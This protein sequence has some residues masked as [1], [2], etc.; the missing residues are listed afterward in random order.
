MVSMVR[1]GVISPSELLDEHLRQIEA[2]N[3]S[4]N[5]FVT[6][7]AER[8]REEARAREAQMVRGEPLGLLHGV[9]L[10]VK[11]SFDVAGLPTRSGS[12]FRPTIPASRDASAVSR[13]R[14]EGAIILGKTNTPDLLASYESDNFITGRSNN[15]WDIC[16]TPGGSSGGEAAAIAAFCSPGGIATDGGGSI[17]VPAHFCGIAGLKPTPGRISTTGHFPSMGH[18][19]GLV[20]VAGPMARDATDL[21]LLFSVLAGYDSSDPFSTPVPLRRPELVAETPLRIGMWEQFYDVPVDSE[22]RA[23]VHRA[24]GLLHG[25]CLDVSEFAPQGLERGPN[26]W[27]FLFSQWPAVITRALVEGREAEA[28]WTLLESLPKAGPPSADQVLMNL[29]ARDRMRAALLRQMEEVPVLLMP[30]CGIPAFRHRERHWQIDGREIGIFQAMMPVVLANVLGLPAVTV[31]MGL[32][33][34]GLPIGIQLVGR[35]FEDELLLEIAIRLEESRG[36][37]VGPSAT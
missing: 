19:G 2:R 30:V 25:P 13:L 35:P 21:H 29:G 16:R 33:A 20:G 24:A 12:R 34:A 6:V 27:A 10:T 9:P 1:D 37:F 36:P 11:D 14:A 17:R 3:P 5:A 22:I 4:V 26:L 28:H 8:A 32:T 18:P 7:L 31:P 23:A 15:P